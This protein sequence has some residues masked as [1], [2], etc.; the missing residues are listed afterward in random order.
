[1]SDHEQSRAG[2]P[3]GGRARAMRAHART[4]T[5]DAK[6]RRKRRDFALLW[7]CLSGL[8]VLV[9]VAFGGGELRCENH[10]FFSV[11][12]NFPLQV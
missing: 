1:M 5:G 8:N 7:G 3:R 6:G 9:L 4:G 2:G 11:Y 10:I 12:G